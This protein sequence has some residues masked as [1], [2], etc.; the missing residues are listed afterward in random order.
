MKICVAGP[1]ALGSLFAALLANAGH[2]VWLLDHRVE[3]ARFV[4]SQGIILHEAQGQRVVSVRATADPAQLGLIKLIFL[5][6]KSAAAA[7]AV[8]R[9][10]PLLGPDSLV[11]ALQNGIA[12][13]RLLA[14]ILPLWALGVTAQGATML[15][16]GVVRH[17]GC[18]PTSVGFLSEVG[19]SAQRRLQETVELMNSAGIATTSRSDILAVAWHKLI[20]NAGINALTALENC[21]NGDLLVRPA[22]LASLKEAVQEAAQVAK[23]S[24]VQIAPDPV[25]MTIEVCRNTA[26]NISSMLQDVRRRRQTEVEAINGMIVRQAALF[27]IQVPVNQALLTGVQTLEAKFT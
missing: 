4:A 19:A 5:C 16:P 14:E 26:A 6:V 15:A 10:L 7:G 1:G 27:G 21:A 22:A 13:H 18:G 2:E 12:H 11:V 8:R 9:L 25:G 23:A 24:G 20:V 17:G 3:R